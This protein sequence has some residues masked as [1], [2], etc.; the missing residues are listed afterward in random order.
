[1]TSETDSDEVPTKGWGRLKEDLCMVY[2]VPRV[3]RIRAPPLQLC[4]LFTF[5]FCAVGMLA[6]LVC[7]LQFMEF[8]EVS[9]SNAFVQLVP[10]WAN[11]KSLCY[12]YD[13]DC[14]D[15]PDTWKPHYCSDIALQN[16]S[17]RLHENFFKNGTFSRA[18]WPSGAPKIS[19]SC[20][21]FDSHE[22]LEEEGK[23]MVM[24]ARTRTLQDRCANPA[25]E[26]CIWHNQ[27]FNVDLVQNV[28]GFYLKIRHDVE[29]KK[30]KASNAYSTGFVNIAGK[31]YQMHCASEGSCDKGDLGHMKSMSVCNR[32][33]CWSTKYA[34]YLSM[35]LVLRAANM[36]LDAQLPM[37][38]EA[39]LKSASD[40]PRRFLGASLAIDIRY[41][42]VQPV[43]LWPLPPQ[44]FQFKNSYTYTFRKMGD[45]ASETD[46]S[47]A[48][49]TRR[50]FIR[51]TG[52]KVFVSFNGELATT[53]WA[54]AVKQLAIL[55][56]VF[57]LAIFLVNK[58]ILNVAFGFFERYS[59]IP[60]MKTYYAE[61]NSPSHEQF[62]KAQTAK[63]LLGMV[64]ER[65]KQ[66]FRQ[67]RKDFAQVPSES[68]PSESD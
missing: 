2:T 46:I 59:H 11:S 67:M 1:M 50:L 26:K 58:F 21:Q 27:G 9:I 55:Q 64:G 28:E 56:V 20:R 51:K 61:L 42:N 57:T 37:P 32:T 25:Q 5:S 4:Y 47:D 54:Y 6:W 41:E 19:A 36:S 49:D 48:S 66:V 12:D 53:N 8:N 63:D 22:V 15:Q 52:I 35:D 13:Y 62:R 40:L 34:D 3:A 18:R 60:A 43:R 30:V 7:T 39:N 65:D 68:V 16:L 38:S 23:P 24:T 29:A 44:W 17:A 31:H 33:D 10:P 14:H 45:Y